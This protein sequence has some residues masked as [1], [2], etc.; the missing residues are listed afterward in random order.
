MWAS[1]TQGQQ[2]LEN[3]LL[4]PVNPAKPSIQILDPLSQSASTIAFLAAINSMSGLI[5]RPSTALPYSWNTCLMS[6]HFRAAIRPRP[7][8]PNLID[9]G[10][11]RD[12][13]PFGPAGEALPGSGPSG[14]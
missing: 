3:Q 9:P 7:S 10:S 5:N 8:C 13:E 11:H 4:R 6:P 1:D 12:P 14:G 2:V